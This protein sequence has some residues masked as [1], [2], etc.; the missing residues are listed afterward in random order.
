MHKP[1]VNEHN[2]NP[3]TEDPVLDKGVKFSNLYTVFGKTTTMLLPLTL[4]NVDRF[5]KFF[6]RRT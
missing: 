3:K 2:V 6:H 1:L 5:S 4:P